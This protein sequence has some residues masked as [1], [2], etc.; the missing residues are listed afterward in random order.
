MEALKQQ[1]L[2]SVFLQ[3]LE[4]EL[5]L[6]HSVVHDLTLELMESQGDIEGDPEA[7][8]FFHHLL[9]SL[10]KMKELVQK[11]QQVLSALVENRSPLTSEA[12]SRP[13]SQLQ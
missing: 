12:K 1:H 4:A 11:R 3:E 7:D 2:E 13:E 9:G 5:N 10:G 8:R 6:T